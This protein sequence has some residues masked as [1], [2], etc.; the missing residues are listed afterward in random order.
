MKNTTLPKRASNR[1]DTAKSPGPVAVPARPLA[2][3]IGLYAVLLAL[4]AL[5]LSFVGGGY[6][7]ADLWNSLRGAAPSDL[8]ADWWDLRVRRLLF[9][10]VVGGALSLTGVAFQ[11]VLR[12]PLAEPYIL[13]V[14]GGA[15]V[16]VLSAPWWWGGAATLAFP[17]FVG[18]LGA[19]G[20][21]LGAL[22]WARVRDPAQLILT[23]AVLNAVFGAVILLLYELSGPMTAKLGLQ[24]VMGDLG[25]TQ[26]LGRTVVRDLAV[27]LAIGFVALSVLARSLDLLALGDEEAADLGVQPA[28]LRVGV[29]V[30]ASIVT[31][32]V[33]AAAGPIGF[34]GLIVPHTVRR[35]HGVSH[36]RL[37]PLAVLLG[38]I[39]LMAADTVAR[40]A[41][42]DRVIPVGVVTALL[43]GPFF[44]GLLR[45]RARQE[46]AS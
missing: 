32:A 33:V 35:W 8:A 34:I 9:A 44:I 6:P 46:A 28:R 39:F 11:A 45:R 29:L 23:G 27:V 15:S 31:A 40:C 1:P 17:A 20:L 37:L 10:G 3:T 24:W 25:P 2:R 21:L 41:V 4:S 38:A 30:T 13:G 7:L 43:G 42:P 19:L 36:R 22:S 5:L 14:S 16:G 12:N 26:Y 18:A